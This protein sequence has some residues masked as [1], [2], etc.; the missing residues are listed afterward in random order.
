MF[1]LHQEVRMDYKVEAEGFESQQIAVASAG[2]FSAAK[3]LQNGQ[4]APKGKKRGEFLLTRDDG[5]EVVAKFGAN[6]LDQVPPIVIDGKK[7]NLVQPLKWY[8]WVWAGWPILLVFAGGALG[9]VLGV[10]ATSINVRLFRSEMTAVI[11]YILVAVISGA[12]VILYLI[13]ALLI[14]SLL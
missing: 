6:F 1:D 9:A 3:I 14:Q 11:Q 4:P 10:I 7:I 2:M 5:G 8:Q 13:L 12:A